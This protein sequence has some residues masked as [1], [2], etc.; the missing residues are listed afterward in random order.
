MKPRDIKTKKVWKRVLPFG[1]LSGSR[2]PAAEEPFSAPYDNLLYKTISQADFLR[3]FY[4]SGHSINDPSVYPDIYKEE[5]VPVYDDNGEQTGT[6]RRIYKEYVPRY[7]FAFQQIIALKQIIHLCG[8]DIQWELNIGN[9]SEDQKLQALQIRTGWA[10]KDMEI[11]FYEAVKSVKITGD[12]A[13]VGYIN[14]G[15]FGYKTLSFLNG[16]TL[17]PHFDPITGEPLLFARSYYDYDEDGNKITEWLEVWDDTYLIR[18]K[19][20]KGSLKN[21]IRD[22]FGI[23]GYKEVDRKEHGFPFIPVAYKRDDDGACWTPSQDS[24]EGYE[25]AFSQMAQNNQAY[26]FPILYLQGDGDTAIGKEFDMNGTIKVLEMGKEDKAGYLNAPN[27]SESFMKQ[28]DTLYKLIYEQS[29]TVIPPALKSGDLPA[30]ALKILYSPAYE[31]AITDA[32]EFQP[33][34]NDMVKIFLYGYGLE[35]KRT[36]DFMSLPLKWWIKPY[37]HVSESAMVQ[38]LATSV[39]NGFISRQTA[40]EKISMYS[41]VSE[42][43]RIIKEQKAKQAAELEAEIERMKAMNDDDSQIIT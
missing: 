8:N 2:F 37:V 35:M 40:S 16:D 18:Y 15:V 5:I 23:D 26:G 38:D 1:Y 6:T 25:L 9:P 4:P 36:I 14:N 10:S 30:A 28:L 39:Q 7:A 22:I 42:W 33:F 32:N 27:A 41:T 17:Y 3:E 29:F 11:A 43:D 21:R 24:I 31:K 20:G 12:V 34:L 19:K 13:H